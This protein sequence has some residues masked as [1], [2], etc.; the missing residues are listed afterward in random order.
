LGLIEKIS[1]RR[2]KFMNYLTKFDDKGKR[3]T[4]YPMDNTI[5]DECYTELI[6]EGFVEIDENE[7]NYYVGNKGEGDN[8]TGYIRVNGKPI[9]AP[10]YVPTK[11]EKLA[12]LEAEYEQEKAQLK[13]YFNTA[14][15]MDDTETQEE[16]KQEMAE[17]ET[18]YAEEKAEIEGK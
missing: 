13:G 16:L 7:W 9:S 4:S 18:W 8:G 11:D 17:L 6:N 3:V 15:L 14:L 1:K 10:P 2:K 5:T 12:Q